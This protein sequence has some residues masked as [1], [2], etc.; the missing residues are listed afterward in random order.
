[1]LVHIQVFGRVQGV[2]FRAWTRRQA[3]DLNLSGWVRNRINGS[4]EIMADGK[5]QDIS[6]FLQLCQ[7]GPLFARVDKIEPVSRPD[8]P[9]LPIEYGIFTNQATV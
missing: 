7:K 5:D 8:A 6:V 9:V 4:V 3:T 1:M 2:G